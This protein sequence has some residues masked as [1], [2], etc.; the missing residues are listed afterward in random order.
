[1]SDL[2][3]KKKFFKKKKKQKYPR[4]AFFS[5]HGSKRKRHRNNRT[6]D[7]KD[8]R[9]SN[10][11]HASF[12]GS[13]FYGT[14][15]NKTTMKYCSFNS[16]E[17]TSI[18]FINCNFKGSRFKGSHFKN[19]LFNNCIFDKADFRNAKFDNCYIK[20]SRF[21]G[22]RN[23]PKA[24]VIEKIPNTIDPDFSAQ[25][26]SRYNNSTFNKILTTSNLNRL[27]TAFIEQEILDGLDILNSKDIKNATFSHMT[28]FIERTI[29]K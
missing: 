27:N 4:N 12:I 9:N 20:G 11:I 6:F 13:S 23:L 15:F 2:S 22:A 19:C 25:L 8:F 3:F 10:S 24:F 1:M 17:F 28:K 5:Y 26:K 14:Y 7:F 18:T 21:K 16:A 29:Q